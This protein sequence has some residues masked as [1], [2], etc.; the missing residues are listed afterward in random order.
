MRI[1][2]GEAVELAFDRLEKLNRR[3]LRASGSEG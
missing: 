1:D 3:T 2:E